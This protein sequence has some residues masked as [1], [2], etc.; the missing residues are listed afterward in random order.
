MPCFRLGS[1]GLGVVLFVYLLTGAAGAGQNKAEW[2]VQIST[3]AGAPQD[4]WIA[5][6]GNNWTFAKSDFVA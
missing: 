3:A 2:S 4:V 5:G 6:R 1:V